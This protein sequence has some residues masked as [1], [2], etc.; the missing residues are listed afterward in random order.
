MRIA[1]PWG[2]YDT[3]PL[4]IPEY[5]KDYG[6]RTFQGKISSSPLAAETT[7]IP[8]AP[9]VYPPLTRVNVT[10]P[11]F[12]GGVDVTGG[13]DL[14]SLRGSM[15]EL[16]DTPDPKSDPFNW[17]RVLSAGGKAIG[18]PGPAPVGAQQSNPPAPSISM[19]TLEAIPAKYLIPLLQRMKKS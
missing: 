15:A 1:T 8:D 18:N 4:G 6:S 2:M 10:D 13:S 11:V 16:G 17:R 14:S 9:Q 5:S 12:G 19:R 3:S 7:A